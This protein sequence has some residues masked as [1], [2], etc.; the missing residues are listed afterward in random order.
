MHLNRIC[1]EKK[2]YNAYTALEIK[3]KEEEKS[4]V[5]EIAFYPL[6]IIQWLSD[7]E[8]IFNE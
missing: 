2:I 8:F 3:T 7:M 4:F 5:L 6:I 1:E